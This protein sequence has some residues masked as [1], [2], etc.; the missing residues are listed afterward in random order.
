MTLL[1]SNM[2]KPRCKITL[3]KSNSCLGFPPGSLLKWTWIWKSMEF[4]NTGLTAGLD[5]KL[6]FSLNMRLAFGVLIPIWY[7]TRCKRSRLDPVPQGSADEKTSVFWKVT[8]KNSDQKRIWQE[9]PTE[10]ILVYESIQKTHRKIT[11]M[12]SHMLKTHCKITLMKS[13][14][15]KTHCEMTLMKSNI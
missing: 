7:C 5:F 8:F 6:S 4:R 11:L 1:K 3:L 14:M 9:H 12:K 10:S 2:L 13:N 15:L